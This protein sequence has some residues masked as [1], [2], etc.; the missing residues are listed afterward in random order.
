MLL[1]ERECLAGEV[2]ERMDGPA[3][4]LETPQKRDILLDRPADRLDPALVEQPQFVGEFR[5]GR[6]PRRDRGGKIR[7]GVGL[8]DKAHVAGGAEKALHPRFVAEHLPEEV[9]P[10]PAQQHVA[11]VEDDDQG[12]VLRRGRDSEPGCRSS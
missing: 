4:R 9:A 7:G 8:G 1:H 10:V 5:K 3:G 11:D 2:A 6:C 12:F